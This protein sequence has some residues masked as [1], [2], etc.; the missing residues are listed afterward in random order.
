MGVVIGGLLERS[1][2]FVRG[3]GPK[4]RI[5]QVPGHSA[6]AV[7]APAWLGA[8]GSCGRAAVLLG[9]ARLDLAQLPR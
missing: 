4:G 9:A 2:G 8:R 7:P 5:G 1:W 6:T 3:F